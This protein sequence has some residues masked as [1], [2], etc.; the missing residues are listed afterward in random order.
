MRELFD[1]LGDLRV[2]LLDGREN[3]IADLF[4]QLLDEVGALVGGHLHRDLRDGFRSELGDDGR[5]PLVVETLEDG[6]RFF[7]REP[8]QNLGRFFVRELGDEIGEVFVVDLFE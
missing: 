7:G 3:P 1:V 4:R 5:L 8:R 6:G 2:D